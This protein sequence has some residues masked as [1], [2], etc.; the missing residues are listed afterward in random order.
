MQD[1]KQR[2]NK[3]KQKRMTTDFRT[4]IKEIWSRFSLVLYKKDWFISKYPATDRIK[5]VEYFKKFTQNLDLRMGNWLDIDW[6][7]SFFEQRAYLFQNTQLP[8][9]LNYGDV[10]N[11]DFANEV[12]NS[13]NIY[14]SHTIIWGCENVLYSNNIKENCSNVYN[15]TM[16]WQNSEN[17]YF[18]TGVISSSN[19]FYSKYITGSFDVRFSNNLI[20]CQNCIL[21]NN[22][23]NQSYCIRNKQYTKE[24]YVIEKEKI[25]AQ[26]DKFILSYKSMTAKWQNFGSKDVDWNFVLNSDNVKDG[27]FANQLKDSKNVVIWWWSGVDEN[28]YDVISGW[29][30]S[31]NNFY[32]VTGAGAWSD[33]IYC[34]CHIVSSNIYYS[35]FMQNCSYCLW[36]LWL[37]NKQFCIFNKQYTKEERFKK[38]NEIFSQMD[39][40]WIL[41]DFFPPSINP[42]YFNDTLAYLI[43]DSFTKQEVES[44]WY[45]R[46]DDEIKVDIPDWLDVVKTSELDQYQWL[47]SEWDRKI[48]PEILKKVIIDEQWNSYRIIKMEYDFLIKH[49]LPIPNQHWLE[50]IKMW[51]KFEH[52]KNSD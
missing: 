39:Q 22:L 49:W 6:S 21:C 46:R 50:R 12:L 19:I 41:W 15:S 36:C 27:V 2:E 48:D 38:A 13:K 8:N 32:A 44:Q 4:F 11:C 31:N 34:S 29:T 25:L 33:N 35:Y 40:E 18:T 30:L 47:D 10:E 52:N 16:V 14:L 51:F 37:T 26:K 45:L 20:S 7:K 42:Y 17:I 5:W 9:V 3:I 24:E 43:D 28:M 23:E 1:I